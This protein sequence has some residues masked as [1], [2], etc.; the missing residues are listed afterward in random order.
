VRLPI[1]GGSYFRLLPFPAL[2]GLLRRTEQKGR[3]LVMYFHPWELDPLQPHMEGPLLSQF[4][5]YLNLDKMEFR[6]STLMNTFRFGP[7]AEQ[8]DL[9]PIMPLDPTIFPAL[10]PAEIA[11]DVA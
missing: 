2:C 9:S 6:I 10:P 1:A 8:I 5:H 7:I 3:P 11:Q 4:L